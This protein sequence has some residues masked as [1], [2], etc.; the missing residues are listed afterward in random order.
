MSARHFDLDHREIVVSVRADDGSGKLIILNL[1]VELGCVLN[2]VEVGQDVAA[3]VYDRTGA[4]AFGR[5]H[6]P[7]AFLKNGVSDVN[8]AGADGFIDL[9]VVLFIRSDRWVGDGDRLDR[10]RV[11]LQNSLSA[12]HDYSREQCREQS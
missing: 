3:I 6:S 9:D 8:Y 5:E 11:V 1:H 10:R 2:D 7:V 4:G 12:S